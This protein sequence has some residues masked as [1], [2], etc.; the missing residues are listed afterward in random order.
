MMNR[1]LKAGLIAVLS[2]VVINLAIVSAEAKTHTLRIQCIYPESS[3]APQML[4]LFAAKAKKY[5]RGQVDIKLFWPGQLV[6]AKKGYD[7]VSRGVIEG[8][9]SSLIYYGGTVREGKVEW[10]PFSWRSPAEAYDIYTR[11]RF[12]D[13]MRQANLK[14]NVYYLFPVMTGTMGYMTNFPVKGLADFKGKKVRAPGLDGQIVKA[15]GSAPVSLS[16]KEIY[17][18]LRRGTVDGV[19]YPYYTLS[20]YKLVE[21]VKYVV[22]PGFHSPAMTGL[23]LNATF[24]KSLPANLK[25]ALNKAG[26]EAFHQ[27]SIQSESWD[28]DAIKAAK[29]KGVK[30]V[31]LNAA[32]VKK[33]RTLCMPVW[34][35]VA[36]STPLSRKMVE[37]LAAYLKKRGAL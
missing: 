24:W 30:V 34:K 9:F 27:S 4:K 23:Y 6:A 12:F 31:D 15:L 37:L 3:H 20:S 19:V 35:K 18:A 29:A 32:Q 14:H 26:M 2:L 22:R 16:A 25:K 21:V 13:L 7:A 11:T 17:M 10:L 5:T 36:S 1:K 28:N 33:I 8:L